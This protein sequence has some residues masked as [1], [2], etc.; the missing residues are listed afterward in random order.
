MWELAVL[1]EPMTVDAASG[2]VSTGDGLTVGPWWQVLTLHYLTAKGRPRTRPPTIGFAGLLAGRAYA[3]VYHQRVIERLCRSVGRDSPSL[4]KA[5]C[6]V[7]G[8]VVAGGDLAFDFQAFPRITLRLVWYAGDGELPSSAVLLLPDNIGSFFCVEDIVV[9]SERLV[10][11][12]GG[13]RF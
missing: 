4:R 2:N 6:A 11:H 8:V 12:L 9:L 13:G 5:A 1:N 3:P 10:S 7:G